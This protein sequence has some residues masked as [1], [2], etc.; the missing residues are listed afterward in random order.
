MSA[1]MEERAAQTASSMFDHVPGTFT[2]SQSSLI[3]SLF[4]MKRLLW[5]FII[6]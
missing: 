2:V 6:L 3:F 4:V 5:Y 1:A